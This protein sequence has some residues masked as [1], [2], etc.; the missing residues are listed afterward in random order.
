MKNTWK[1][2]LGILIVLVIVA[3]VVTVPFVMR[4]YMMA[5]IPANTTNTPSQ[6]QGWNGNGN[7]WNM[8]PRNGNR[9]GQG[10]FSD[11][12]G[13][14]MGGGRGFNTGFGGGRFSPFGFG[15]MFLGGILHLIPLILLVLLLWGAYQ[16][17]RRS[18]LRASQTPAQ[19]ANTPFPAQAQPAATEP[20]STQ[21]PSV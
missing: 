7:G 2:I 15:F 18:G 3:A 4:N 16:L 6:G 5:R 14:M 19:V 10:G 20:D 21:T 11:R 8:L 1:W 12:G 9:Q 17:G 13:P